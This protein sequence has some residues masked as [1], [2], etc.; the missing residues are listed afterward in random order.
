MLEP[1]L[2]LCDTLALLIEG[3]IIDT[4]ADLREEQK[5]IQALGIVVDSRK[6]RMARFPDGMKL[7]ANLGPVQFTVIPRYPNQCD[8]AIVKGEDEVQLLHLF[9]QQ[10]GQTQWID[11]ALHG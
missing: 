5:S 11:L 10:V 2:K 3:I 7:K 4:F 9:P 1:W 8:G 6:I